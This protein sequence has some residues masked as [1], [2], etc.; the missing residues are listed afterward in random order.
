MIFALTE[1]PTLSPF[2]QSLPA[3]NA[4]LNGLTTIFLLTG[5]IFIKRGQ[6]K[7][8]AIS[9]VTALISSTAFL[10]CY[11]I[12]HAAGG[13]TKFTTPGWPAYIYYFILATHVPLAGLMVPFIIAAVYFAVRQKFESHKAITR[14]LWPVWMYV[15]VTGVL[16]Y[17]ML[18]WLFPGE[19]VG[20]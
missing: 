8:H 1:N 17:V 14:W 5:W 6:K 3:V 11:L 19:R 4:T 16:I 20:L 13:L 9:M 15:S 10:T 2:F 12:Y 18:Y 7:A